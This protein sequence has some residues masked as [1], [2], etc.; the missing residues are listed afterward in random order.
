MNCR[1]LNLGAQLA[2]GGQVVSMAEGPVVCAD[3]C[4]N[5]LGVAYGPMEVEGV[6]EGLPL[7][8][9]S[10]TGGLTDFGVTIADDQEERRSW[11]A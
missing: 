7:F 6:R 2:Y 4:R 5:V 10:S 3:G 9:R 8:I 11:R 1:P